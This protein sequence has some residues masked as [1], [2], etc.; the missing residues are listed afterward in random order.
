MLIW[1]PYYQS[2]VNAVIEAANAYVKEYNE[3]GQQCN[4]YSSNKPNG[5]TFTYRAG[6]YTFVVLDA[7]TRGDEYKK[8]AEDLYTDK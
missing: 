8:S 5:D 6:S 3:N 1:G 4:A 2:Q 7:N